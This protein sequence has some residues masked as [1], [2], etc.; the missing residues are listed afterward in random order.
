MNRLDELSETGDDAWSRGKWTQWLR[1]AEASTARASIGHAR[2]M[3]EGPARDSAKQPFD[4]AFD[5]ADL[6][7]PP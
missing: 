1:D 2:R 3:A 5:F 6:L 7:P 4:F